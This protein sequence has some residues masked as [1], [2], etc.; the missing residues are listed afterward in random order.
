V[1]HK[2]LFEIRNLL[3]EIPSAPGSLG[4]LATEIGTVG[5]MGRGFFEY[6]LGVQQNN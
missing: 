2:I 4:K 3:I 1:P 6:F 5:W